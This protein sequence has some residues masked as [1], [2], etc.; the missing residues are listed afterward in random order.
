MK[1]KTDLGTFICSKCG[2]KTKAGVLEKEKGKQVFICSECD[3]RGGNK[4]IGEMNED[5]LLM[6]IR[7]TINEFYN[8]KGC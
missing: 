8:A 3:K 6:Y 7:K 2:R 4:E 5:E 1:D